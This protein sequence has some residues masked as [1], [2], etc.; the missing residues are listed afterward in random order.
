MYLPQIQERCPSVH[1]V[2][3]AQLPDYRLAFTR[4]SVTWGCGAADVVDQLKSEVWGVVYEI[5]DQDIGVLDSCE[6]FRPGRVKNS[7]WRRE[8]TVF[9]KGDYQQPLT[10]FTYFGVP[11]PNPP[12][13]KQAYKDRILSGARY[14]NLPH[15]YLS[16]LDQIEVFG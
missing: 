3:I 15:H 12:L 11:Q 4:K 2:H 6:G 16:K 8:C 14:W 13:P 7:Y 5:V 9:P 10:V 1:F